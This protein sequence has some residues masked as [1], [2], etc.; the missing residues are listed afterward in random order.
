[1]LGNMQNDDLWDRW[2]KKNLEYHRK[3]HAEE[4][5][6]SDKELF[7]SKDHVLIRTWLSKFLNDK[8][9]RN[10]L[11]LG[12]GTGRWFHILKKAER[13]IGVDLSRDM[14]NKAKEKIKVDNYSDIALI[15]ADLFH[16]PLKENLFDC[17]VSIGVLAEHAPLN[18]D[19]FD[20]VKHILNKDGIFFFTAQKVS[21]LLKLKVKVAQS[22]LPIL[23]NSFKEKI[24]FGVKTLHTRLNHSE[25]T[26]KKLAERHSFK[27]QEI[28]T[29]SLIKSDFYFV[30]ARKG[31]K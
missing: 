12:C 29:Y 27:I 19:I 31:F 9:V 18:D 26:I 4:Y 5:A 14:L 17:V 6:V 28:K 25:Q 30:C 16:L 1:M 23:P 13:A 20:E 3:E 7:F 21:K 11:D 10:C 15:Q 8:Q 2:K 24:E 22:L